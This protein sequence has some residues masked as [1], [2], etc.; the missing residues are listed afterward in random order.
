MNRVLSKMLI[1]TEEEK[2]RMSL[3]FQ[4]EIQA[5]KKRELG[6]IKETQQMKRV[7]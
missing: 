7:F 5:F 6:E 3:N 4:K 1:V 2:H